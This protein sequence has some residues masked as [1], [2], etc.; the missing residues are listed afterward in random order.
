VAW[1]ADRASL[2]ADGTFHRDVGA[3]GSGTR[4]EV[5]K[6]RAKVAKS[7][8]PLRPQSGAKLPISGENARRLPNQDRRVSESGAD[9]LA[10]VVSQFS[11]D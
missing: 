7:G 5:A 6:I 1:S 11:V 9:L 3:I 2:H 10:V 8:Q 4:P